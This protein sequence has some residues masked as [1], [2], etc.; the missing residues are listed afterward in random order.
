[1]SIIDEYVA[2]VNEVLRSG[3][4]Q[5]IDSVAREIAA[6][7]NGEIPNPPHYRGAKIA[8]NSPASHTAAGPK[9]LIGKP[10]IY[11]FCS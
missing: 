1:M 4:L 2:A 7:F 5:K 11:P 8:G 3:D 6:A 10:R 9:K